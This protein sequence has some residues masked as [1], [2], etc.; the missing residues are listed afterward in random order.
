MFFR[1][2]FRR[3]VVL[4]ATTVAA[5]VSP[6]RCDDLN[7]DQY[8]E[9]NRCGPIALYCVCKSYGINT[10][11]DEL[12][13]LA[14][15][16]GRE[17]SAAGLIKAAEAKGLKAEAYESSLRHLTSLGGPAIID[18]P[19]G[20]FFAFMSWEGMSARI[21]DPP[22]ESELISLRELYQWWGRHVIVFS[23]AE[24]GE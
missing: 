2:K 16:D 22:N 13:D 17:T 3:A 19:Q 23:K 9:P 21:L 6:A 5:L 8:Y 12:A 1:R 18:Y 20:H 15:F 10:T 24:A 7:L 4:A 11:I 14:E